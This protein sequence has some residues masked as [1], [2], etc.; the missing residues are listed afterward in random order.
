MGPARGQAAPAARRGG[1]LPRR[2]REGVPHGQGHPTPAPARHAGP[3]VRGAVLR[4]ER[5]AS[6]VPLHA[7]RLQPE[8]GA[9]VRRAGA[10]RHHELHLRLQRR[11]DGR[12]APGKHHVAPAGPGPAR[13]LAPPGGLI[14]GRVQHV[15]AGLGL[16]DLGAAAALRRA[17]GLAALPV[18]LH[19]EPRPGPA[20]QRAGLPARQAHALRHR[21]RVHVPHGAGR[22]RQPRGRGRPRRVRVRRHRGGRRERGAAAAREEA[23]APPAARPPEAPG[24][25]GRTRAGTLKVRVPIL[26]DKIGVQ[27]QHT[28]TLSERKFKELE[29]Y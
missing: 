25:S 10:A 6:G 13:A 8:H 28:I 27:G 12:A 9:A 2:R 5:G 17:G 26:N 23:Q 11:P 21:P 1:R 15:R 3:L 4:V 22:L 20:G 7:R 19:P 14:P 24:V 16:H 29:P 18:L